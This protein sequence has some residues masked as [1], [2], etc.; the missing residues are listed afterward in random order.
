MDSQNAPSTESLSDTALDIDSML[1][2]VEDH[3]HHCVAGDAGVQ[4]AAYYQGLAIA[5][6]KSRANSRQ[7][8]EQ[9]DGLRNFAKLSDEQ[10]DLVVTLI[11]DIVDGNLDR[12]HLAN[13]CPPRLALA[14]YQASTA[15]MTPEACVAELERSEIDVSVTLTKGHCLSAGG[16]VVSKMWTEK[17]LR[18]CLARERFMDSIQ[19]ANPDQTPW[20]E[21]PTDEAGAG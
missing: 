6:E 11:D 15:D 21:S 14:R 5:V 13:G 4:G 17:G 1:A 7:L 12:R 10:R 2:V 9:L 19:F 8:N 3:L 18:Y 16:F 20:G